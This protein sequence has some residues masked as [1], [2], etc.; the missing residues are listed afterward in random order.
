MKTNKT[1]LN[2]EKPETTKHGSN[3]GTQQGG[4][5]NEGQEKGNNKV[6]TTPKPIIVPAPQKTTKK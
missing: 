6:V 3:K 2:V 5:L 1:I 4:R